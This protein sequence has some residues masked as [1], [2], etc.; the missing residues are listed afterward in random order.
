MEKKTKIAFL[1]RDGVINSKNFNN[2][3][4]DQ[5]ND[6]PLCLDPFTHSVLRRR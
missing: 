2:G 1:D 5:G 3:Y 4:I 6:I